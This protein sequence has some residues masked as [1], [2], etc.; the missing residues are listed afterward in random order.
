MGVVTPPP[1][2]RPSIPPNL[3]AVLPPLTQLNTLFLNDGC[4]R[5]AQP[6]FLLPARNLEASASP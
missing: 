3:Q 2:T 6:A 5:T 4:P 1:C